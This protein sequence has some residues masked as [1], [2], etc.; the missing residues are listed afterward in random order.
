MSDS[1][2]DQILRLLFS[3]RRVV[4]GTSDPCTTNP[5]EECFALQRPKVEHFMKEGVPIHFVIPAFP[6]KSPNRQKTL[7]DLPDLGERLALEFLQSFCDY[8]CHFYEPGAK[9]TICSDGHVFSDLVGVADEDVTAYRTE[10]EALLKAIGSDSITTYGLEDAFQ[11]TDYA[12]QRDKLTNQYALSVEE[13]R[14]RALDDPAARGIFDGMHRFMFEDQWAQSEGRSRNSVRES[15]KGL[16]YQVIQR[17]D[18]WSVLV[19]DFFPDALRLS[20]HPQVPH[21]KKIGVH[22][23]RTRDNWLTPWHGVALDE[24]DGIRLVKR[25]EAE[26]L[27]AT[28]VMRGGRPSHF[29]APQ[30]VHTSQLLLQEATR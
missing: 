28:V 16:A 7:G 24:G 11:S 12:E 19:E 30:A 17:S 15:S 1:P 4:G 6:A 13:I 21:S 18:A 22:M 23:I 8:V 25:E 3:S 26:R 9:I 5:C 10:L 20:I 27:G 2:V 14:Q 29:I